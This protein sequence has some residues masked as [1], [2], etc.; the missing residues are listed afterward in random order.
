MGLSDFS[1]LMAC[2]HIVLRSLIVGCFIWSLSPSPHAAVFITCMVTGRHH[3]LL[4]T[5]SDQFQQSQVPVFMVFP[6]QHSVHSLLF[7][8]SWVHLTFIF[9]PLILGEPGAMINF[10]LL[11][12]LFIYISNVI[13]FPN[14]PL[15]LYCIPPPPA[16]MRVCPHPPTAASQPSNSLHT[17]ASSLHRTKGLFPHWFLARPSSAIYTARALG[18]SMCTL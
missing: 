5:V 18:P 4:I 2:V 6:S 1:W 7:F 16:T 14:Y 3:S 9:L 12:I 10:F 15:T 17:G 8:F 11:D 13:P